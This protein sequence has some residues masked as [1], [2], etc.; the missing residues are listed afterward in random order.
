M[1]LPIP[2]NTNPVPQSARRLAR[3][4]FRLLP[5]PSSNTHVYVDFAEFLPRP[6]YS[7]P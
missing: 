1:I 4:R 2:E 3:S 7:K 5:Y 6:T